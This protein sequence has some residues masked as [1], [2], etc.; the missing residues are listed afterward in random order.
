MLTIELSAAQVSTVLAG[1]GELPLK[2]SLEVFA[3]IRKQVD[4]Q[5][6]QQEGVQGAAHASG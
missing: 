4:A 2:D 1:L 3:L 5:V 6:A